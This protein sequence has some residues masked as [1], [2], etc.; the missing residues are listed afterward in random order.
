MSHVQRSHEVNGPYKCHEC[1]ATFLLSRYLQQHASSA[2]RPRSYICPFCDVRS[3]SPV[4]LRL[5]CIRCR[6]SRG[7][8]EGV[9]EGQ[10]ERMDI[11]GGEKQQ[12]EEEKKQQEEEEEKKQ[13]KEQ[14]ED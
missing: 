8:E 11:G 7:Q 14:E 2:H 12:E 9:E 6:G 4:M 10:L 5:H 13:Q 1:P 3:R